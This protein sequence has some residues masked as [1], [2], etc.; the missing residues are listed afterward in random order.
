MLPATF[1]S[2]LLNLMPL[3]T[4]MSNFPPFSFMFSPL[5]Q[6][7]KRGYPSLKSL[8]EC[9]PSVYL[10]CGHRDSPVSKKMSPKT[11]KHQICLG[12]SSNSIVRGFSSL[13]SPGKYL[14]HIRLTCRYLG[15]PYL[16]FLAIEAPLRSKK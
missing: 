11:P 12:P 5:H 16:T 6:G 8:G 3:L 10:I 1:F 9:P 2:R 13:K 4:K 7:Y 15:G 14:C